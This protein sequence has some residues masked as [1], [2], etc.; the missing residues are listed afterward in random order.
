MNVPH[1]C[2]KTDRCKQDTIM[3]KNYP[4]RHEKPHLPFT[5]ID[6]CQLFHCSY[7]ARCLPLPYVTIENERELK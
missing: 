6:N 2:T 1:I 7:G 3:L 5:P 4:C